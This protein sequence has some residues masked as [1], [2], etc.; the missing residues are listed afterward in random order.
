MTN[1]IFVLSCH[2]FVVVINAVDE[3][4]CSDFRFP[5]I[6]IIQKLAASA[7]H[8]V[9]VINTSKLG[10]GQTNHKSKFWG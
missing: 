10:N 8:V 9:A 4:G 2:H 6:G 7:K 3:A 5:E 1:K